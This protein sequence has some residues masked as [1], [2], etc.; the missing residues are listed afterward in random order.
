MDDHR[1][2]DRIELLLEEIEALAA[3]PVWQRV[4]E[5]AQRL[6][7]L[8]GAGLERLLGHLGGA[9]GLAPE[10]ADR[11]ANDELVASLLLLHGLHPWPVV[12]R[13]RQALERA[14][15]QLATVGSVSL[16]GV[17]GD[18]VRLRVEGPPVPGLS[19]ERL[20]HRALADAVPELARVEVEGLPAPAQGPS[21]VQIDL[22]RTRRPE[23]SP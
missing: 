5:L 21:L 3:G 16:V 11:L 2:A 17:E 1:E 15:P 22:R 7:Q 12:E 6:V 4:E 9:N 19:V 8:Y 23:E 14:R 13:V 18:V 20:L 10:L